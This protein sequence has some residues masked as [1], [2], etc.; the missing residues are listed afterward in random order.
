[1]ITTRLYFEDAY[2]KEFSAHVVESG[3]GGRRVYLDRTA[4]YP[5]SGGQPH[6]VG[7]IAG[8]PVVEV[9]DEEKRIAHVTAAPVA[10]P[11][12]TGRIDWARRFDHM[13]QHTGQH[14]LSAVLGAMYEARTVGFHL[15]AESATIDVDVPSL[16]PAEVARAERRVNEIA[17][18]NRP[19]TVSYEEA[20]RAEG[21]R[22]ASEREGILRIVSIADLD[23]S[24]CGG[25]HVRA[26]GEIGAVLIRRLEKVRGGLRIEFLCGSRAV[27]RARKDFEALSAVA[28]V[29]SSGLDEAPSLA[30]SQRS[31]LEAA[32]KARRRAAAELARYRGVE[33]YE[34]TPPGS[35]GRRRT[36]QRRPSGAIDEEV[37]ALAQ[38]F[39]SRPGAVFVAAFDNPAAV[40]LAVAGDT[41]IDAGE[42][43]KRLFAEHGGRGGGNARMAQGSLPSTDRLA[44]LLTALGG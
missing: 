41:G 11:A 22:R 2:L 24:A 21:L 14:L 32:D 6:D 31:A 44:A 40:L 16:E 19:V 15:G 9:V 37:R 39:T 3:D 34:S 43:L 25:T 8:V 33:L 1:M 10:G 20:A 27:A 29:F 5:T 30:A 23:R 42:T 18:E 36:V 12:V 17:A 7:E 4:F 35:D 38:G 28:R 26:T 13:Q